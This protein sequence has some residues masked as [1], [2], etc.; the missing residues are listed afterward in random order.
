ME[1]QNICQNCNYFKRPKCNV[2]NKFK[3]RKSICDIDN[4]KLDK[5]KKSIINNKPKKKNKKDDEK[6]LLKRVFNDTNISSDEI[7]RPKVKRSKTQKRR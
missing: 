3:S 6:E 2:D 5:N 7:E 1:E 4:F